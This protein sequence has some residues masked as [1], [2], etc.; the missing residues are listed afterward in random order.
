MSNLKGKVAIVTGGSRGI[1]LAIAQAFRSRGA[2]VIITGTTQSHL[3]Q[4]IRAL[5]NSEGEGDAL[6]VC[7]DVRRY[8]EIEQLVQTA[9]DRFGGIDILVNNAGVGIWRPVSDMTI[10]E[11]HDVVDTNLTGV[12]YCCRAVIPHLRERGSSWIVN[13]SSLAGKNPFADGAA[14]CASKCAL[15]AFSEA[16][17]QEVRYDGIRV[18]YVMPGSVRTEFSGPVKDGDDWKLS[19]HD[20]A[21][22]VV[23]L[24]E[25][26]ARSLPSRVEIRPARPQKRS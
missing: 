13:I 5:Q 21:Q 18:A 10:D 16:M 1:G 24:I 15:N 3:D 4:A 2:T 8:P 12:F 6:A 25:H 17:M 26:P 22:V 9:V 20:V 19:P 7:A 14:Y 23:D 11:W